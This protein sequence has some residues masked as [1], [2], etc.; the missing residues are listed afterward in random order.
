MY[1]R[2]TTAATDS[3]GRDSRVP[4]R[5]TALEVSKFHHARAHAAPSF[6]GRTRRLLE[7]C[8]PG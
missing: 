6:E 8:G 2:H 5:D 4:V 7:V 1:T 3:L